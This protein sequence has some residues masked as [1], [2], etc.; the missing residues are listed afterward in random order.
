MLQVTYEL[1]DF[2]WLEVLQNFKDQK[3]LYAIL[4]LVCKSWYSIAATLQTAISIRLDT[5]KFETK[6]QWANPATYIG[7]D[8]HKRAKLVAKWI[9]KRGRHLQKLTILNDSFGFSSIILLAVANSA[10]AGC[11]LKQLHLRDVHV[12]DNDIDTIAWGCPLIEDLTIQRQSHR[13]WSR[14]RDTEKAAM[15]RAL[16]RLLAAAKF[17]RR[18]DLNGFTSSYSWQRIGG[19]AA[20]GGGGDGD[21]EIGAAAVA[22]GAGHGYGLGPPAAAAAANSSGAPGSSSSR[23]GATA[24]LATA[25]PLSQ[26]TCLRLHNTYLLPVLSSFTGLRELIWCGQAEDGFNPDADPFP[27]TSISM[28]QQLTRL[29]LDFIQLDDDD[30]EMDEFVASLE[31]LTGLQHLALRWFFDPWLPPSV[32]PCLA[33]LTQL[34]YLSLEGCHGWVEDGEDGDRMEAGQ[35]FTVLT[36]LQQLRYLDVSGTCTI[37]PA[38][39]VSL[40][41][42]QVIEHDE[43]LVH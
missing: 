41:K 36:T 21:V 27:A 10:A 25:A 37:M 31:K 4:P 3:T 14:D 40:P 18:V 39:L 42:L 30:D 20:A 22:P 16:V 15:S 43:P 33:G 1:S 9:S 35:G 12:D 13:Y 11:V 24:D 5:A 32:L 7:A 19:A 34:T 8:F 2:L 38:C 28:L 29:E 6:G 17:L 23:A 26:L